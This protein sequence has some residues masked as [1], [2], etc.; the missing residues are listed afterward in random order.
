MKKRVLTTVITGAVA[1]AVLAGCAGTASNSGG[2]AAADPKN[3]GEAIR[4][5]NGKIDFP[6]QGS[7]EGN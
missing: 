3:A 4:I 7:P 1:M 2:Q 6:C 5:V